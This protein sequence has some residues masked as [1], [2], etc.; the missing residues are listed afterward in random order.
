MIS[1]SRKQLAM[2]VEQ[3]KAKAGVNM[4]AVDRLKAWKATALRNEKYSVAIDRTFQVKFSVLGARMRLIPAKHYSTMTEKGMKKLCALLSDPDLERIKMGIFRPYVF[5]AHHYNQLAIAICEN[6]SITSMTLTD[7][8]VLYQD[9]DPGQAACSIAVARILKRGSLNEFILSCRTRESKFRPSFWDGIGDAIG[10][11]RSLTSVKFISLVVDFNTCRAITSIIHI[12]TSLE[13]LCLDG[14]SFALDSDTSSMIQAIPK[15]RTLAHLSMTDLH[16]GIVAPGDPG[17]AHRFFVELHRAAFD[18]VALS[19]LT[20]LPQ[21]QQDPRQAEQTDR[22]ARKYA[23]ENDATCVTRG[24]VFMFCIREVPED[25]PL[26]LLHGFPFESEDFPMVSYIKKARGWV[27]RKDPVGNKRKDAP[28]DAE[29]QS[30]A[31]RAK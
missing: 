10:R 18:N 16:F 26:A 7:P 23:V 3:Q 11:N 24:L 25:R 20:V 17:F 28:G 2:M 1:T 13:G 12:N 14:C 6:T 21:S 8:T 31:K 9:D 30:A 27:P 5:E 22:A 19:T 15:N 29:G 4:K